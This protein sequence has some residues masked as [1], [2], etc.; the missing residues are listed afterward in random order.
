MSMSVDA[1]NFLNNYEIVFNE[2]NSLTSG[3]SHSQ[4]SSLNALAQCGII[5]D[6]FP[7]NPTAN[8]WLTPVTFALCSFYLLLTLN[9]EIDGS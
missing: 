8:L 4:W 1:P 2:L 9:L 5:A 3:V 6:A 7:V